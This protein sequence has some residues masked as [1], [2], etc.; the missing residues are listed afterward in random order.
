[1]RIVFFGTPELAV[2]SLE[3]V[4]RAH[5]VAAVV[6]QPDKP[7]GRSNKLVPPPVKVWAEE[8]GIA[9]AQP[10][11]LNDGT[12]ER[13]LRDLQPDLC[14]LVAYGRLLKQ[15]ILDIPHHGF[16]NMHPSL[17]PR[18]RGPSPIQTAILC[19]DTETGVTIMRLD[20]GM[21]TGDMLLQERAP[22]AP[23]D[24]T[25][26]LTERL[27][28]FGAELLV[29][30]IGLVA[31]GEAVFTPQDPAAATVT[32]RYEKQDGRIR[33]AASAREI[34]NLVRAAVPWPV[35]H[36]MFHGEVCRI[37]KTAPLDELTSA[38]P[39]VVMRV[40]R[41]RI[42]VA[43]GSGALAVLEVQVPGKRAMAVSDFLRGHSVAAGESL[44][45]A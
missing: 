26:S 20:A 45:D 21:D 24:T 27:A 3:G 1:M 14:A 17:L 6:C 41:D 25:A 28:S 2:P 16:L 44:E 22:I 43:A 31:S 8:H 13:W 34:H 12:F 29:R 32:R 39:G 18:H 9:V 5:E 19:G 37:H 40:E 36:C 15:P 35:A 23:D 30:G 38:E 33:W 10:T 4:A 42:V 11:A 7:Q